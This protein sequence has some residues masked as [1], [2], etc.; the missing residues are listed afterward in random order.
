MR[1]NSWG[2]L[3]LPFIVHTCGN[4]YTNILG[5]IGVIPSVLLNF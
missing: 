1:N 3:W 4:Q 5:L 2:V